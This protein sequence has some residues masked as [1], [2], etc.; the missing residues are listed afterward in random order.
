M[1]STR[2]A[3]GA[4]ETEEIIMKRSSKIIIAVVAVVGLG[5][6]AA[7]SAKGGWGNCDMY[8]GPGMRGGHHSMMGQRGFG[9]GM[10]GDMGQMAEQKLDMLKY[11]LRITEA[12]EPSWQAFEQAVNQKM[13]QMQGRFKQ[14]GFGVPMSVEERVAM[15]RESAAGMNGLAD[16]IDRLYAGLTPEQKKTVDE[17]QPMRMMRR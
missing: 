14:R 12:Q 8:G 15:M 2:G 6:A 13:E 5:T 1:V 17:F 3:E 7:V 9:R 11:Q 16:A 4:S 10:G